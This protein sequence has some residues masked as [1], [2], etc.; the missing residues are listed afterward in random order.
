MHWVEEAFIG[1]PI[2]FA[3]QRD[4]REARLREMAKATN[5]KELDLEEKEEAGEEAAESVLAK[6]KKKLI[7]IG[8]AV[9]LLISV[10][11]AA[12]F[13][14]GGEAGSESEIAESETLV[15]EDKA[16]YLVLDPPFIINLPDRGRQRFLQ[17]SVT[18]MSRSP[19]A[20]LTLQEHMPAIRHHLSIVLSA[21]SIASIQSPGGIEQ[22]RREATIALN[23]ILLEEYG[24][25]AIDEV[26]FTA[27]VMQ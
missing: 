22:V 23:K 17:A 15:P 8:L 19:G 1:V 13:F 21:Q 18:V 7:L 14:L 5:E 9:V 4:Y 2:N 24:S 27:F 11:A 12:F 10:G 20:L 3:L 6:F 25:D 16:E 26:L